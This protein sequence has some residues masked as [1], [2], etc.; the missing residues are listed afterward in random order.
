M[1]SEGQ[2]YTSV[3]FSVCV[4][5]KHREVKGV[6]VELPQ[7]FPE[8]NKFFTPLCML[9]R[10]V[11]I[12]RKYFIFATFSTNLLIAFVLLFLLRAIHGT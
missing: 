6:C 5:R 3:Y 7:T 8:F 12:F 4:F 9:F 1:Q 2:N 10:F 11:I